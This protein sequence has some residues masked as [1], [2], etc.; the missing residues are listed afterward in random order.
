MRNL[1]KEAKTLLLGITIVCVLSLLFT[2][3]IS[4]VLTKSFQSSLVNH[5]Y[6]VAGYFLNH[7]D[8]FVLSPVPI[9]ARMTDIL[10]SSGLEGKIF[11]GIIHMPEDIAPDIAFS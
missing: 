2:F 11:K 5:D 7:D 4:S 9:G 6:G 1:G 8:A 3:G 10:L